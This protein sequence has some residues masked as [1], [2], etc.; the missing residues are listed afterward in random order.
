MSSSESLPTNMGVCAVPARDVPARDVQARTVVKREVSREIVEREV[1]SDVERDGPARASG[2]GSSSLSLARK[3][4]VR[5][6][7]TRSAEGEKIA[8]ADGEDMARAGETGNGGGTKRG[9]V[10]DARRMGIATRGGDD[11]GKGGGENV[12]KS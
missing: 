7:R 2:I 4:G 9:G 1:A 8:W 10:T 3:R 11:A 6:L 5:D 12:V